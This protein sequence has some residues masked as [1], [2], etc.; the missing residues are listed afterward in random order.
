MAQQHVLLALLE[1][2]LLL[3]ILKRWPL[4]KSEKLPD[5]ICKLRP[6]FVS[7]YAVERFPKLKQ[8][9]V[10]LYSLTAYHC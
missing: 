10:C 4:L 3:D 5:I 1:N 8:Y 7:K 9:V 2:Q 6:M